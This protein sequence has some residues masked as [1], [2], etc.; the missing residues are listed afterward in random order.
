MLR[1]RDQI[2]AKFRQRGA[3]KYVKTMMKFGIECPKTVDQDLA[4]DKKNGNTLWD[5]AI[6][7]ETKNTQIAF[8]IRE[9]W[10]PPT[11]GHHFI[12]GHMIISAKMEQLRQK[13]RMVASSH[14]TDT[15]P[16]TPYTSV[17]SRETLSIALAM[18]A[19]HDLSVK[20][21]DIMNAYIRSPCGEK[22]YIILGPE[23][24][25]D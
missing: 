1:K 9:K 16:T 7:K 8:D 3:K 17:V 6:A 19:L 23:F 24:G 14:I 4:L 18:T 13:A 12:K 5:D 11:V 22:V 10:D 25:L 2:V 20:T 15:P 21:A